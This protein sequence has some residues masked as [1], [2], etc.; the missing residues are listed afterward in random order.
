MLAIRVVILSTS[1]TMPNW[2]ND[3][4]EVLDF[5]RS[6]RYMTATMLEEEKRL[7]DEYDKKM[8]SWLDR[9]KA[10]LHGLREEDIHQMWI[11][12]DDDESGYID[13]A[14]LQAMFKGLGE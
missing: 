11:A 7:H 10:K 2:I 6:H 9:I 5:R 14:E 8:N 4:R 12:A 13:D 1:P 3:A